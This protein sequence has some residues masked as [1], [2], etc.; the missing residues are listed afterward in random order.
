MNKALTLELPDIFVQQFL[1]WWINPEIKRRYETAHIS[2]NFILYAAQVIMN[3]NAPTE[4][5]L[6]EEVKATVTGN[7]PKKS[8]KGEQIFINELDTI[9]QI[10]LTNKDPNAGH[11]TM[12]N[13]RGSW[14][15]R[16]DFRYN[17]ARCL[18]HLE[19]AREFLNSAA[20]A[21]ERTQ[22]RVVIDN[23]F[24]AC[25]LMAKALLL[26]HDKRLM[27]SKNHR[28]VRNRYNQWGNLGNTDARY[29]KLLNELFSLRDSARYL[30]EEL[31]LTVENARSMVVVAEGMFKDINASIPKRE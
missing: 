13:H 30:D 9:E 20:L 23:L 25:E 6:N 31:Q 14:L 16:F 8:Q 21:V 3:L 29:T 19:A 7:L 22:L 15:V 5:R 24:S 10:E 2:D 26:M 4:V 17:A 18:N 11:L 1:D 12:L 28:A 27:T